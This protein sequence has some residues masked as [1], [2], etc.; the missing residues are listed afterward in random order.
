MGGNRKEEGGKDK[1]PTSYIYIY[2][3]I[4]GAYG[5]GGR[6]REEGERDQVTSFL[7]ALC[8]CFLYNAKWSAKKKGTEYINLLL[9]LLLSCTVCLTLNIRFTLVKGREDAEK[10]VIIYVGRKKERGKREING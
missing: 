9:L 1:Y 2:I 10:K 5:G 4:V 8:W 6:Q 3:Y 7:P